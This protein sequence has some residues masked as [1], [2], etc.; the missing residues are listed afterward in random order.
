MASDWVYL[1]GQIVERRSAAVSPMDRGFLYGDGFF[2]TLRVFGGTPFLLARH[3]ARLVRSCRETGWKELPD[4]ERLRQG[5][6]ALIERTDL[7]DCYLRVTVSPGLHEGTLTEWE[8]DEPTVFIEAR[9]MALPPLDDPPPLVLMKSSHLVNSTSP[10]VRHK[11]LSYQANLLAL[12]EARRAG[13]DEVFFLNENG[14]LTEG[15]ITNLFFI[16]DG[17]VFTPAVACGLLPGI[18]R[19]VVMELCRSQNIPVQEGEYTEDE[20]RE[21]DEIFCTNSLKG[22]V[23][24]KEILDWPELPFA[25]AKLTGLQQQLYATRV[26]ENCGVV[27]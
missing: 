25:A 16:R 6:A 4:A 7:S 24:V 20:L 13:A 10:N 2:E 12:A 15:A 3:L 27:P 14:R 9:Q 26:R 22:I 17:R 18:T 23:R 11:S 5:V 1:N 21:A 8:A 19:E